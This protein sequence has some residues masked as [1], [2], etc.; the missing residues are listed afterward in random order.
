MAI[1]P[2]AEGLEPLSLLESL[3]I[4]SPHWKSNLMAEKNIVWLLVLNENQRVKKCRK[5]QYLLLDLQM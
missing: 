5:Q 1:Y 3:S 4:L 2:L